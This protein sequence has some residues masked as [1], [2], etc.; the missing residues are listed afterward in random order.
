M[1]LEHSMET[2]HIKMQLGG[3]INSKLKNNPEFTSFAS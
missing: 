1:L 3:E 2:E